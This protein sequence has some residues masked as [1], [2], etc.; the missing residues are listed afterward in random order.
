MFVHPEMR[1]PFDF[2]GT[3]F[4]QQFEQQILE[5]LQ[6]GRKGKKMC[7]V[8]I[9]YIRPPKT[10]SKM[11]FFFCFSHFSEDT[12]LNWTDVKREYD[13]VVCTLPLSVHHRSASCYICDLH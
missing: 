10:R 1:Y 13:V 6:S 8:L 7:S 3:Y 11:F 4:V 12:T 2:A 5:R 9:A